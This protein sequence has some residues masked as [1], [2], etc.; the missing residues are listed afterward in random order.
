MIRNNKGRYRVLLILLL[1][2]ITVKIGKVLIVITT[3]GIVSTA[4][5]GIVTTITIGRAET[6]AT[7]PTGIA[8]LLPTVL[9]TVL[10]TITLFQ[11][12]TTIF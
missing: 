6:A 9:P 1:M 10:L 8:T 11:V 4:K 5:I 3:T 12:V 7:V 2:A